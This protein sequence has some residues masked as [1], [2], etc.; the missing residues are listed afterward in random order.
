MA[1]TLA[2]Q[3]MLAVPVAE[4]LEEKAPIQ[5][6]G[7]GI[8]GCVHFMVMT[9]Y[10]HVCLAALALAILLPPPLECWKNRQEPLASGCCDRLVDRGVFLVIHLGLKLPDSPRNSSYKLAS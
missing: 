1:S 2:H 4:T 6:Q 9:R 10:C 8:P 3:G 7:I 5:C